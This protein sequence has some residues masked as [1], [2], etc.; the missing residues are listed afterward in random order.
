MTTLELKTYLDFNKI[1]LELQDQR[2]LYNQD[3]AWC[4]EYI[5]TI[6]G[7]RWSEGEKV[8]LTDVFSTFLYSAWLKKENPQYHWAE[9]KETIINLVRQDPVPKKTE[10][11]VYYTTLLSDR[12]KEAEDFILHQHPFFTYFYILKNLNQKYPG[13]R[14][15]E[16][17]QIILKDAETCVHYIRA[18]LKKIWPEGEKKILDNPDVKTFIGNT[19]ST[20]LHAYLHWLRDVEPARYQELK[21]RYNVYIP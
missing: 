16:G 15:V 5:T 6:L 3:P 13:I 1:K 19:P 14:W 21:I 20:A 10:Y 7:E 18:V 9:G 17:E 11:L 8:I 4:L 2:R 12:W